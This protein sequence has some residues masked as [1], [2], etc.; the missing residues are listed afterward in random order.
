MTS[1]NL[2]W[3]KENFSETF[4]LFD[5]GAADMEVSKAIRNIIPAANLYAF[6]AFNYWHA[7]NE[8]V[9]LLERIHYYKGA[10]CDTDGSIIFHPCLTQHGYDHPFSGSIFKPLDSHVDFHQQVYG[11]P[12]AINCIRLETFCKEF[13]V[14]PDFIHIDV[15]GAEVKV[16]QNIGLYKPKCVWA[17]IGAFECYDT[18]TSFSA[19][20]LLMTDMGYYMAYVPQDKNDA[21]Y[22]LTD[23]KI[24]P[25]I[26]KTQ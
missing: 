1:L 26:P 11:D 13:N 21:L 5:I 23:F 16:F 2:S 18:N 4:T 9:A 6:E 14:T 25:Y 15:E 20:N 8:E 17:E 3:V 10:V 7:R 24:T 12:Y 22:C 19:F